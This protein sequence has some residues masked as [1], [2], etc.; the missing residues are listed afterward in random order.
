VKDLPIAR[1]EA[2]VLIGYEM[3][4]SALPAEHGFPARLVVPRFYGTN[5]V[6]WLTRMTLVE[7]RAPGPF[8]TRWYNYPVL[9]GSRSSSHQCTGGETGEA[10]PVW[11]IAP[12]CR[13]SGKYGAGPGGMAAFATSMSAPTTRQYGDAPSSSR[14]ADAS[15]S[16]FRCAGCLGS[17][18]R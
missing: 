14:F 12:D 11:S 4:G 1:V 16:A 8:T 13:S 7:S 6:K 17:A 18:V 10:T 3:N 2:D 15:G 9:D 5:S